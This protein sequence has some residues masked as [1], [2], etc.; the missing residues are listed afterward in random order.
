MIILDADNQYDSKE[1]PILLKPI[2]EKKADI[3]L[4]DR[5][6][7]KLDH[8]PKQKKFLGKTL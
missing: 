6:I 5:Q 4:G 8:M 3:V 2:L 7:K 1:I